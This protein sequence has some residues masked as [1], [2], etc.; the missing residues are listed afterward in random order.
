MKDLLLK[1]KNKFIMYVIACFLPVIDSL[2][3]NVSIALLIGSIETG[4]VEH[5]IKILALSIF[6]ALLGTLLYVVSRFMR[7]SYMRDTILDVRINAFDR[8]LNYSYKNFSKKSKDVYISNLI[9][10][11]N[12]FE[13]NFFLRLINTIFQGG[14][15][16][17]SLII[18][19]FM[20]F[21]FALGIFAISIIMFFISKSF[22]NKTVKLQEEVSENNENFTTNISNTF[23]GIEILKLNNIEQ[24]FLL[25]T[26]KAIDKV[27]R[28]KLHYTVFTEGQRSLTNF[29]GFTIFVGIIIYSI[30]LVLQGES[31]TKIMLMIQ[32]SNGCVWPIV[33]ILPWFNELK[34]SAKIYDKITKNDEGKN[35][36]IVKEKE[37]RFNSQLEVNNLKFS[38]DNKEILKGASFV[39]EKGKKYLLKGASGA[40]KSTLINLLSM[41]NDDYEG[42]IK[43]DDVDYKEINEKGFN[44]HISF[45][46]QDVFLFEDTIYNNIALFK[47][48]SEER[49]LKAAGDAGLMEFLNERKLGLQEK[50]ME[51]GKNLSG[52]QRQRI[53]IARAIA[54]NA[55]I[56]FVDEATSSLN[57]ELGRAIEN[58]LLSL[59]ST[60][61]AISH[62]YYEG[63]SEKYD[64]VLE[65]KN[66]LVYQYNSQDY[67][68]MEVLAI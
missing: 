10:D 66:G 46:Y 34:A 63:I 48:I 38:Y 49:V 6:F 64:Y 15:Y 26:L 5:F 47:D 21:K 57:K 13:Q 43:L 33:Q 68:N 29:F 31:F 17:V 12:I 9:N 1:R 18:L 37:F 24:K 60:V 20:D 32:L 44:E 45:I 30:N 11:I 54:K 51:N 14:W 62:R 53:S 23:N 59:D 39:I 28:K 55:N 27:E 58:T 41:V 25:R 19:F 52:G 8:I 35:S 50:L 16:V 40:G 56:L 3:R 42:T 4:E 22:E 65:V 36:D 2:L 67:F 7:I 61:I